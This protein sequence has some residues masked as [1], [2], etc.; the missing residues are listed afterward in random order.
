MTLTVGSTV[1]TPEHPKSIGKVI[2]VNEHGDVTVEFSTP[3][4]EALPFGHV[5]IEF[6]PV[7]DQHLLME[8]MTC[9]RCGRCDETCDEDTGQCMDCR[10]LVVAICINHGFQHVRNGDR[11]DCPKCGAELIL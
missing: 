11:L 4:S 8:V 1:L 3:V 2:R 6:W 5:G 7:S 9:S 10:N